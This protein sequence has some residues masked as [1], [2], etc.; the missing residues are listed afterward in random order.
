[1]IERHGVWYKKRQFQVVGCVALAAIIL[2]FAWLAFPASV[3]KNEKVVQMQQ[4]KPS[5][6]KPKTPT[7]SEPTPVPTPT[8]APD[9]VFP[10]SSGGS[11][12]V[13]YRMQTNQKV[14]FLTIDDG[15]F[16]DQSV[17]AIMRANN[18][19]ASLFLA[20]SFISNDPQ[21]FRQ[22]TAMGSYVED[23]TLSHDLSMVNNQGYDQMKAE[24]CGMADYEQQQYGRRPVFM[25]PPGGAYNGTMLRAAADCGM[26][27]VVTWIAKVNGG[28]VQYQIGD[29]LRPGDI[30]LMH[31]RPE[32]A[33]DMK[34]FVNAMDASGLHTAL[35]EDALQ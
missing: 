15:A 18:I 4:T 5:T 13:A 33:A 10:P 29:K 8:V 25:R 28:A 34:A 22:L 19:K 24:I 31:F 1:M 14:V 6:E 21:F 2:I 32:F 30:V 16:K 20:K 26:K 11:A 3:N 7:K 17:V 12:P 9:W 27:A 23:H 35:L